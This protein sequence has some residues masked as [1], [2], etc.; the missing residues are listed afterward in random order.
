MGEAFSAK[1]Q[2]AL[3]ALSLSRGALASALGV[4]KSVVSRW[5][6]GAVRPS[7]HNLA[8]LT[9]LIAKRVPGFSGLDWDRDVE[10]LAERLGADASVLSPPTSALPMKGLD[11]I[12]AAT[13]I[14]AQAYEGFFRSTRPFASQP[15][16][17]VHD[18]GMMRR[19]ANGFLQLTFV[20]G[21]VYVDA[22]M[23]PVQNQLFCVGTERANGSP[24]FG[25]FNGTGG[26]KVNRMDG[27]TLT[28]ALDAARTPTATPIL[29]E[30]IGDLTGDVERDDATFAAVADVEYAEPE[31][32]VDPAIRAHL[33]RDIG[34][35]VAKLGGDLLMRS[36][37]SRSWA[38]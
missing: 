29:I 38:V 28:S 30:R 32:R 9:G 12:L 5:V 15:G 7:A 19:A 8:L 4:D 13:E 22:W 1:L 34:P 2:V 27:L 11:M 23:L 20:T 37:V 25:I 14:R 18:H 24:V 21:G 3:K 6:T 17:F 26:L 31:D 16:Y 10:G 35:E 33:L 36:P